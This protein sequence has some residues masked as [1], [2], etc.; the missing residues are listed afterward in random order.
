MPGIYAWLVI[1]K[2]TRTVKQELKPD[3][4]R[5]ETVDYK[6]ELRGSAQLMLCDAV[7]TVGANRLCASLAPHAPV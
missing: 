7:T 6:P 4:S 3:P 5:E 1:L 2:V